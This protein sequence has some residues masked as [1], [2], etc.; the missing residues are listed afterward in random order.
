MAATRETN[1]LQAAVI[2]FFLLVVILAVL[3]YV[4]FKSA[5]DLKKKVAELERQTANAN[6]AA[7]EAQD[8]A[9]KLKEMIGYKLEDNLETITTNFEQDMKTHGATFPEES[10]RYRPILEAMSRELAAVSAREA[11]SVAREQSLKDRLAAIEATKDQQIAE[12]K[13][14][15]DKLAADLAAER[16][17]FNTARGQT[18]GKLGKLQADLASYRTEAVAKEGKSKE[19]LREANKRIQRTV[20]INEELGRKLREREAAGHENPDGRVT[21]VNQRTRVAWVNLGEGDFLKRHLNFSVYPVDANN[22]AQPEKKGSIEI[23]RIIGPHMAEAR[24]IEDD[25]A[26]P[27]L[28]G[29]KIHSP[30]WQPGVQTSFALAGFL[31]I[32]GDDESDREKVRDIIE[33]NGGK[34]VMEQLEDGKLQ[35]QLTVNTR[36][37]VLGEKPDA[38]ANK[39]V[40][41]SYSN[42]I[43]KAQELGIERMPIG[44]FI[45]Q[46]GWSADERTVQL[47]RGAHPKDFKATFPH[48]VQPRSY[49]ITSEEFQKR[50]RPPSTF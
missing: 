27:I 18:T 36:Y 5:D 48:G 19:Q 46:M 23:T 1:G 12:F 20:A 28:P 32:D 29:D 9:N 13:Q 2:I 30:V 16:G 33:L 39:Q 49:G 35:G 3:T 7:R 24:I 47:G 6:T 17:K 14:N 15:M 25:P 50:E 4:F 44:E 22:L 41:E 26:R 11:A 37:L 43:A 42:I 34:V 38:R 8:E 10:R 45:G 40:L 21:W 31:D